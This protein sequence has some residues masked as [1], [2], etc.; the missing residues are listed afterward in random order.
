MN[1]NQRWIQSLF[2]IL[3]IWPFLSYAA[4]KAGLRRAPQPTAC[5][6]SA[7]SKTGNASWSTVS[8]KLTNNCGQSIDLQ[9]VLVTFANSTNLNTGFW[10]DFGSIT[11][12]D[13]T[14][15]I[16]SQPMP[17]GFL[18]S[19]TLHIPEASWANSK[20]P[21]GQSITI[22]YGVATPGYNAASVNVY[23]SSTVPL[24]TGEIDLTNSTAQ[25]SD[26]AQTYGLVN[27][28][29]NGQVIQTVQVPWQGQMPVANLATGTYQL[30]PN[31][32]TGATGTVYQG[33]ATP[34]SI[35]LG[36]NQ[37][38]AATIAYA[39]L[40][41]TGQILIKNA[42]LPSALSGYTLTPSVTLTQ[43]GTGATTMKSVAWNTTTTVAQLANN[44]AFTFATPAID[45]NGSHCTATF[46]PTTA[47]SSAQTPPTVN[48]TY[49]CVPVAQV[50][51]PLSVS[52]LPAGTSSITV[53]FTPATGSPINVPVTITGGGGT[54]SA[55]LTQGAS[56]NLAASS[57]A[58]YTATFNPQPLVVTTNATESIT[59]TPVQ[60]GSGGRVMTY[61]PGWEQP[62]PATDLS[63]AG[64]THVFIAFGVFSTKTP[65]TIVPAFDTV[66]KAYI[67]SLHAA[68]IKVL[69][70]LGGASTS[71]AG[72]S[73]NFHQV[74][75]AAASPSQFQTTFVQS[76]EALITQYG[77]DGIDID[78]ESGLTGSGA[79][80]SPTG[81]V[82]VLANILNQ[83]HADLPNLLISLTP[84]TAN[85][86]ATSSFNA[87]WGN[88]ASLIMQTYQSLS[89]V[90]IQLYN[91]GCMY[92]IDHVCYDPNVTSS[93]NFSVAMATDLL[94]NW[95]SGFQP[96]ISHLRP[97]QVVL[98]YPAPNAQGQSDGTP[99]TPITTIKRAF[100][101]LN[102]GTGCDTY[103]PPRHYG[104]IGGVFNWEVTYDQS[105]QYQ[106]ARGLKTCVSTGV[107]N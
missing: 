97:D 15:Q 107:C 89:W 82:L 59:Y 32:V 78:I 53:T 73:I 36:A 75:Q 33:T 57:I 46:T 17:G 39:A 87:T 20:L 71:I 86:S 56:Y 41:Q 68:G 91:S 69:L 4:P 65:G 79:F 29:S 67:D 21:N 5:V 81:D 11:Y 14:L 8:L 18:A 88:Y 24:Q 100:Q 23:L 96:Y 31:N 51:V 52:G 70:S 47:T 26:V 74:L 13:N 62:P 80:Q 61:I 45:F 27:I 35:V 1:R 30:Q 104:A 37:K 2:L 22:H 76:L 19:F 101:C 106:F 95:P 25:P 72:T 44:A 102:N 49:T 38:I 85:V 99:V 16:T 60:T 77:F 84:Q 66:S 105:N 43:T 64:Y 40:T 10:G 103:V 92:G 93:P 63:N 34:A 55:M 98:G 83:L 42:A 3:L 28:V 12:P 48:L 54:A 50:S 9:N 6:A 90:Q 58:G 7:F 94:E